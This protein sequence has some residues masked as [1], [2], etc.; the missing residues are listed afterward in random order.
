MAVVHLLVSFKNVWDNQQ[1][2]L[3]KVFDFLNCLSNSANKGFIMENIS[4]AFEMK[5]KPS[6]LVFDWIRKNKEDIIAGNSDFYKT[7]NYI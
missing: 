3:L 4:I 6:L 7:G 1:H 5:K 2:K